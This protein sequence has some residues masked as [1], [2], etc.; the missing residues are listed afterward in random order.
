MSSTCMDSLGSGLRTGRTMRRI[1]APAPEAFIAPVPTPSF[2]IIIPAYQAAAF[3]ADAVES[4]LTQAVA[5]AEVI[6]CDDGSTDEAKALRPFSDG[7]PFSERSTEA[8]HQP[9]TSL[10]AQRR[11]SSSRFSMRTTF[12]YRAISK[13]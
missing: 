3:I 13:R 11:R 10:P 12:S 9:A 8:P 1:L 5:P 2:S 7:S 6:V 4:A